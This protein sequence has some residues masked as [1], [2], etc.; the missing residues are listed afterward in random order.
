MDW[1]LPAALFGG[2]A[3]LNKQSQDKANQIALQDSQNKMKLATMGTS[4]PVFGGTQ[5]DPS[6]NTQVSTPSPLLQ[7]MQTA[8]LQ[9]AP[10]FTNASSDL[11]NQS[12]APQQSDQ[13]LMDEIIAS[14]QA[15]KQLV[16]PTAAIQASLLRRG[17]SSNEFGNMPDYTAKLGLSM[18]ANR[19]ER[20][21]GLRA[22]NADYANQLNSRALADFATG[23][24][25]Q[26]AGLPSPISPNIGP[27]IAQSI[28][29]TNYQPN[30]GVGNSLAAGGKAIIDYNAA[31]DSNKIFRDLMAN[32]LL[33]NQGK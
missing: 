16:D 12:M 18:Q 29:K 2:G 25:G 26:V 31:Q 24:G 20:L 15:T 32:R 9:T 30:T 8:S 7:Q 5:Y 4:S 28:G 14:E 13:Q 3:L 11:L 1:L 23:T 22:G 21:Q 17:N 19:P 6:T 10:Q 27:S 33:G